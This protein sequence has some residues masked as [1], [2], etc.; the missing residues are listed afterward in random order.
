MTTKEL[1]IK[2]LSTDIHGAIELKKEYSDQL[3]FVNNWLTLHDD[4]YSY[5]ILYHTGTEQTHNT[6]IVRPLSFAAKEANGESFLSKREYRVSKTVDSDTLNRLIDGI[7][8][9]NKYIER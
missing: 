8:G 9:E 7:F 5:Q 6:V 2:C 3:L 4:N 1:L